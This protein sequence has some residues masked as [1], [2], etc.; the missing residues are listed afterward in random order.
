M[1]KRTFI[2][3]TSISNYK[4]QFRNSKTLPNLIVVRSPIP[5]IKFA[6]K[7]LSRK[8]PNE[9]KSTQSIEIVIGR[10]A[11]ENTKD[12]KDTFFDIFDWLKL[13]YPTEGG[14]NVR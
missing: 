8:M 5:N 4:I 14:Y 7:Y 2:S 3:I 11:S 10:L 9:L 6:K 1:K 13:K 12:Q